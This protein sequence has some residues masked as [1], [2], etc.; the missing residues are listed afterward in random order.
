MYSD[1]LARPS[2]ARTKV[3]PIWL[4]KAAEVIRTWGGWRWVGYALSALIIAVSII[5]LWHVLSDL[6]IDGVV[7]A[8]RA[9]PPHKIY[10]AAALVAAA[11]VTLTFYEYFGLRTIGI[12][13]IPY[14]IAILGSLTGYSIG[15]NLGAPALTGGAVRYRVYSPWGLRILD[16]AK[17]CFITG[18][19]F[20][21]GNTTVLG[22]GMIIEPE[23]V[24]AV[25]QLPPSINRIIG[26]VAL[27]VLVVYVLWAWRRQRTIGRN[28][29]TACAMY[30]LMPEQPSIDFLALAVIFA[31]ATLLGFASHAPG[32][33]GVFDAAML[34]ALSQFDKEQLVAALLL[35]RLL[36]FVIPFSLALTAL[37]LRELYVSLVNGRKVKGEVARLLTFSSDA[38]SSA[39]KPEKK[40]QSLQEPTDA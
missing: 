16:I 6:Q 19:T 29:W 36:Y 3:L 14:R 33:M 9:T 22:L 15:H 31:S 32:S 23:A 8:L 20:W 25:D 37:G 4:R 39:H 18:L 10:G 1:P 7:D 17:L 5:V 24:T 12:G 34:V 27:C 2:G 30:L 26:V 38:E 35:F 11:F 21:L 28:S 13:H 40:S